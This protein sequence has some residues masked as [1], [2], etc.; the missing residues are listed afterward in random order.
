MPQ[1]LINFRLALEISLCDD[2]RNVLSRALVGLLD[3]NFDARAKWYKL[4]PWSS[5]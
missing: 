4:Y 5:R 2:E 1:G 3:V